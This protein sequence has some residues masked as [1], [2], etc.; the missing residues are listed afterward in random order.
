MT[1]DPR[2]I[3]VKTGEPNYWQIYKLANS[4]SDM[5]SYSRYDV[6]GICVFKNRDAALRKVNELLNRKE[7]K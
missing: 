6:E 1:H 3:T 4:A 5:L 7:A 2:Y